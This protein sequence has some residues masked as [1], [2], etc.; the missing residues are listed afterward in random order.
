MA[1]QIGECEGRRVLSIACCCREWE[2]DDGDRDSETCGQ[3]LH[4]RAVYAMAARSADTGSVTIHASSISPTVFH[5]T[6]L[7]PR[8]SPTPM[9]APEATCVVE[10]GSENR[11][12]T[13]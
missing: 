1:A 5:R 12:A 9:M 6:S 11:D 7:P 3:A 4:R 13:P 2:R 8:D 10:T